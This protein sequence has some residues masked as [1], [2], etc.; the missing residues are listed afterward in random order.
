M[1]PPCALC[2][3]RKDVEPYLTPERGLQLAM[4]TRS[5]THRFICHESVRS[6]GGTGPRRLCTGFALLRAQ[7]AGNRL[8][9]PSEPVYG[10]MGEMIA[11]YMRLGERP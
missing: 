2:P 6:L 7:E 3:Y 10:S 1:K 9:R 8:V 11:T 5:R 4:A